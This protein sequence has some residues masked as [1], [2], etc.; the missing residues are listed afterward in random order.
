MPFR[1]K[2]R[3]EE[4]SSSDAAMCHGWFTY[5]LNKPSSYCPT[6]TVLTTLV[7]GLKQLSVTLRRLDYLDVKMVFEGRLKALYRSFGALSSQSK[8]RFSQKMTG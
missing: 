7:V 5:S 4:C 6:V 8:N 2:V 1:V 3:W